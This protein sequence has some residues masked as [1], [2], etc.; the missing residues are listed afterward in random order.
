M[1]A[2]TKGLLTTCEQILHASEDTGLEDS[3]VRKTFMKALWA[4]LTAAIV[5]GMQVAR[6]SV[7]CLHT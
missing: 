4:F 1:R 6:F 5:R 2:D 3:V 7:V